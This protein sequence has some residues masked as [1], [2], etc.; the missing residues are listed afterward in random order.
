MNG[1]KIVKVGGVDNNMYENII[2]DSTLESLPIEKQIPFR[3]IVL[4]SSSNGFDFG[5]TEYKIAHTLGYK[6]MAMGWLKFNIGDDLAAR[7]INKKIPA[8]QTGTNGTWYFRLRTDMD[9]I[10]IIVES[11]VIDPS[12]LPA[13]NVNG[14]LYLFEKDL[15]RI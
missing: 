6:P 15:E 10:Y 1:I 13:F 2:I 5:Y 11:F 12:A 14:F 9:F 8:E 7:K 3:F 4:P